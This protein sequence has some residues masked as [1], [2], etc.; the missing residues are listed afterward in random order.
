MQMTKGRWKESA[1]KKNP[2][3]DREFQDTLKVRQHLG[4]Q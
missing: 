3:K 2:D 4:R 1:T